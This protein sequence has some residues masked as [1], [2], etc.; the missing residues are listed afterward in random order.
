MFTIAPGQLLEGG[1]APAGNGFG[2]MYVGANGSVRM[3]G[4]LP[5]GTGFS[6]SSWVTTGSTVS[7]YA[8][9]YPKRTGVITGTMSFANVPG[10]SDCAGTL[11]W[12]SPG[13][14]NYPGG[15]EIEAQFTGSIVNISSDGLVND[16]VKLQAS[17][18]ELKTDFAA[19]VVLRPQ[20]ALGTMLAGSGANVQLAVSPG[21]DVFYGAFEDTT[22]KKWQ[23][24]TGVL[25]PKSRTGAGYYLE[26][27]TSGAVS[28]RY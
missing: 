12:E 5:D 2:F 3:L 10:V 21:T 27:G 22:S 15:F 4:E 14:K 6:A 18:G 17:G 1:T 8:T 26:R 25:L 24:F 9:P 19:D 11:L 23:T 13:T 28:I 7:I 20:A 16:R